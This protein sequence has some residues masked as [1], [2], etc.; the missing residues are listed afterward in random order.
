MPEHLQGLNA[1]PG[2]LRSAAHTRVAANTAINIAARRSA[3]LYFISIMEC[4][5]RRKFTRDETNKNKPI[6]SITHANKRGN[7]T[8]AVFYKRIFRAIIAILLN[9]RFNYTP[10]IVLQK[11]VQCILNAVRVFDLCS[12]PR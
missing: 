8:R 2:C 5:Q 9:I 7:E 6:A 1:N 11:S 4:L 12:R 10:K 3:S